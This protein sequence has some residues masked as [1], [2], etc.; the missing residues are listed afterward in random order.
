MDVALTM[1]A[2]TPIALRAGRATAGS[3]TLHWVPGTVLLGAMAEA[4]QLLRPDS[5]DEF[6]AF[7]LHGRVQMGN[8][9]PATF[10]TT[11]DALRNPMKLL[12]PLPATARSC[13]RWSGFRYQSDDEHEYHGVSDH[14]L[15]WA[16]FA[17]SG[18]TD[19]TLL[20]ELDSCPEC[21]ESMEAI[22][23]YYRWGH[24]HAEI[25]RPSE[26][27]AL[28]SRTGIN[29]ATGAVQ[30]GILYSRQELV[31]GTVF[32]AH[33]WVD[34]TLADDFR[35]FLTEAGHAGLWRVGTARTRGL[36][37]LRHI[38][39]A[40][41]TNPRGTVDEV[42]ARVKEFDRRLRQLAGERGIQTPHARYVA[43]T[44]HSDI[45]LP[46]RVLRWRTRLD[47]DVLDEHGLPGAHLLYH[48]ARLTRSMSWNAVLG[49]PRPD[50]IAIAQGAVFLF[51][52]ATD[53]DIGALERVQRRGLGVRREGGYGRF[54]VAD[55]F[56]WEVTNA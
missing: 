3:E 41:L 14:L 19:A 29:R 15:A 43:L 28:H 33:L 26:R 25:G 4:H 9:Y 1:E 42:G 40:E 17:L 7:F 44:L 24:T 46:N 38:G 48:S 30:D 12:A 23:G 2:A 36:G 13:K 21:G 31:Q 6:A 34:D 22:S 45:V 50:A 37:A 39:S 32:H 5:R 52:F 35:A 55:P 51:G 18:E 11:Q 27:V 20:H 10:P 53:P 56:H 47:A 49:L 54:M 8:G 16:I